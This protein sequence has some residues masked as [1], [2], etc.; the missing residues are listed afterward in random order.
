MSWYVLHPSRQ[1]QVGWVVGL[2]SFVLCFVQVSI[3]GVLLIHVAQAIIK[4][5]SRYP[6]I[7]DY[8]FAA[9]SCAHF[10]LV[11]GYLTYWQWTAPGDEAKK[12]KKE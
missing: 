5:P 11:L 3:V 6:H 2:I 10:L 7:H 8:V 4:P 9:Y 12:Q 1:L